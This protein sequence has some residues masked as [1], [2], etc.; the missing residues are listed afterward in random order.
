MIAAFLHR[1][2]RLLVL[3]LLVILAAGLAAIWMLPR[4]E[5]PILSRRV[6]VIST[7]YPGADARQV[8]SLVTIPLEQVLAGVPE[9]KQVRSNS[10]TSISNIVIELADEVSD[11]DPVWT[12]IRE[13][14]V[15]AAEEFPP[16]C[17]TPR[18][19][20]F[21]LKAFASILSLTWQASAATGQDSQGIILRRLAAQLRS[22]LLQV[23][24]TE[25]VQ[26]FGDPGEEIVVQLEP[27]TLTS[28]GLSTAALAQQVRD[29]HSQMAAGS[30]QSAES[31]VLLDVKTPA[32][33]IDRIGDVR[34]AWGPSPATATLSEM[35][36]IEKREIQPPRQRAI[37]QGQTAVVLG[38]M[39]DDEIRVD[40]W[41]L[42]QDEVLTEFRRDYPH[43][44]EVQSLFSQTEHIQRRMKV[45]RQNLVLST[46]AVV[47]V[48]LILMGWRSMIVVAMALPLSALLVFAGMR[49]LQIPIHQMSV[50]GLIVALG[51]LIDNAIVMVEDV[52]TGIY[53]GCP[54]LEAIQA[55]VRHLAMPLF[56]S[57]VTTALAF[58]PI[59]TLP[60][61]AGEFVGTIAMSVILAISASFL[62]AMT[63]IPAMVGL[64]GIQPQQRGLMDYGLR[65]GWLER[66]YRGSLEWIFRYPLLGVLAGLVLPGLGFL[67]AFNLPQQ[68]FP[69]AD[70]QQIQIEIER[71]A[72]DNL[73][74]VQ[75]A[76]QQVRQIVQRDERLKNQHWFLGGSAPTF[77]YNVVPRRRGTP[78]YAQAFIDVMPGESTTEVVQ[79]LQSAID[80]EVFD[81]RVIVRQLEQG[82]PF[83]AP[84]EIRVLGSDLQT[85]QNLGSQLRELL[86]E[87]P[88]VIHT[89]SDLQD[90]IPKLVLD[91]DPV[92]VQE[93][94]LDE[95]R[96]V[97]FLYTTVQGADAGSVF[98]GGQEIPVRV[99]VQLDPDRQTEQLAALVVPSPAAGPAGNGNNSPLTRAPIPTTLGSL[100]QFELDSDVATIVRIDGQRVNEVK[101]YIRA[102][103]L[104]SVVMQAFRQRLA[105]SD[106]VLPAGYRLELGGETEQRTRAVNN[107]IANALLLFTLMLL[108]LVAVFQS[109]RSALIIAA[110]GGLSMGLGPL[111]LQCFGFPF[112]FMAI[113]GTMGLVG[114][115]IND[116]IV[117]LAA[118]RARPATTWRDP[119]EMARIV[120]G[121]TRHIIAT[122]VTTIAGFVPLVIGGGEFWPPLAITIAGG[123][124]GATL[125][126]LYFV[127]SLKLV[128]HPAAASD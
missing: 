122:T 106:V 30:L 104:P 54:P 6:A 117:V 17:Q 3:T 9:I 78:Y 25:Q 23:P 26:T 19:E 124:G 34:I 50:T 79:Q 16:H 24:G 74:G 82:P 33:A 100:G 21:P 5:D 70:R 116:S 32:Q 55:S 115:A 22:R 94:G 105:E 125:L 123:V 20:V 111:A 56:G 41:Q 76:M 121:C 110:V 53:Q 68:F 42:S 102:G 46:A 29:G 86:S 2:P 52:R 35:A 99:T 109:F 48:L 77:F 83:D 10:G 62:L 57:T 39:V 95:T 119:Q 93:A 107:L 73:T 103:V 91:V 120:F 118:I 112:G 87:T 114:V 67:V 113:V 64:M 108:T 18:L 59:A 80:R 58:L 40:R 72:R 27:L 47:F 7:V 38:V 61:P 92:A 71:P 97:Q 13:A 65:I 51:L 69:P 81:S 31:E 90:A 75:Q 60:G 84:V 88:H 126:A 45:L 12:R 96:V 15:L 101:A 98:E 127:P 11:V 14:M 63:A 1:N 128:L 37:I 85:L 43:E 89:R 8:E 28:L 36:R 44:V 49:W 4:L 66:W